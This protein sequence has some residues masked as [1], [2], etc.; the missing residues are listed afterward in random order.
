MVI[1][2]TGLNRVRDLIFDDIDKGQL[3][4]GNTIA[5]A[6]DTGLETED[7]T[8]LLTLE[9]S[10][11]GNLSIRFDYTL[12]STGG[13]TTTYREFE[14]QSSGAPYHYDRIVFTGIDFTNAG[15]E[16]INI[17]KIYYLEQD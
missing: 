9:S 6:T 16:D 10:S 4:E 15:T 13:T 7:S 12:P 2:N 1:L 17:T 3:G 14:L 8:T 11:K 5:L